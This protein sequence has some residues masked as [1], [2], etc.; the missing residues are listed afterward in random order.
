MKWTQERGGLYRLYVDEV[1]VA[2]VERGAETRWWYYMA[3]RHGEETCGR[4][5]TLADAQAAAEKLLAQA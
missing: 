4:S 1:M 5:D 3:V 2:Q